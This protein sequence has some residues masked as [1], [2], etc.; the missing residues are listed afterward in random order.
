MIAKKVSRGSAA[1]SGPVSISITMRPTWMVVID[2]VSTGIPKGVAKLVRTAATM[3][4]RA[5]DGLTLPARNETVGR[6]RR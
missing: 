6:R 4:R 2:T 3:T 5:F 1:L